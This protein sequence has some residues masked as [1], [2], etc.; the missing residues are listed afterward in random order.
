VNANKTSAAPS[1]KERAI[2]EFKIYAIMVVYLWVLLGVFTVFRRLVVSESGG[3]SYLHYGIALVEA[4]V[5]GKVILIGKMF[6]FSRGFEGEALIWPVLYKSVVFGLLV[7]LFGV[8]EHLIG[9]WIHKQGALAGLREIAAI[10]VV[11]LAARALMLIVAFVPLFAFGELGRVIG[12]DKLVS[13]FLSKP[14]SS[15]RAR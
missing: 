5:I 11:E 10:G 9:G 12:K 2:E 4:L 1:L 15:T 6:S 3:A 7:M 14:E 8:L 13:L